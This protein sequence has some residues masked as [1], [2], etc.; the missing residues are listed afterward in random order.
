[1]L[2]SH[3][4][5][6]EVE[7]EEHGD[8][9]ARTGAAATVAAANGRRG[10]FECGMASI[11]AHA[12]VG[13]ELAWAELVCWRRRWHRGQLAALVHRSAAVKLRACHGCER[14]RLDGRPTFRRTNEP[15]NT[16]EESA[17]SY[18]ESRTTTVRDPAHT[19][20]ITRVSFTIL[21]VPPNCEPGAAA[22]AAHA[23]LRT[24]PIVIA[25]PASNNAAHTGH[26]YA[27]QS[28]TV[29]AHTSARHL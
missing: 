9:A 22:S 27:A 13:T 10:A 26:E 29:L 17:K 3:P 2:E 4:A 20:F 21:N 19:L 23:G 7:E 5:A 28:R 24:E 18:R 16:R 8:I 15:R 25:T 11:R 1:M 6:V 12:S 14:E